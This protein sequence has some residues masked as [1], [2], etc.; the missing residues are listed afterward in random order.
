MLY[1]FFVVLSYVKADGSFVHELLVLIRGS[2]IMHYTN[3]Y[4]ITLIMKSSQLQ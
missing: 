2:T 3:S 4:Y 1:R